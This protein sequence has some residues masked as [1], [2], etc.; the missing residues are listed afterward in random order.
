M[1]YVFDALH[2]G[3]IG[4]KDTRPDRLDERVLA[5]H[6]A[7]ILGK[8]VQ[9]VECLRPQLDL[10]RSPPQGASA[11]VQSVNIEPHDAWG[12]GRHM[13]NQRWPPE[14]T[15]ISA[16]YRAR[17]GYALASSGQHIKDPARRHDAGGLGR[18]HVEF[19]CGLELP[20]KNEGR[21]CL[22][23]RL[24]SAIS[25][26]RC[27]TWQPKPRPI[28]RVRRASQDCSGLCGQ[29]EARRAVQDL[30]A[31]DAGGL[32]GSLP[33]WLE[34]IMALAEADASTGWVTA[35][36]NLC[37]GLIY[38]SAEPRFRDEF[39]SDQLLVRRGAISR[40]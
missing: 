15:Q 34:M 16:D 12:D 19:R 40:V 33:Q 8:I 2:Q 26:P 17:R 22:P 30:V 35:H 27:P 39:F 6:P 23:A 36:A 38:A 28:A 21:A 14:F 24:P 25:G 32:A 29:I 7:P 1:P 10:L 5:D 20:H 18:S 13:L 9:D 31:A 37:A 3:T 4:D 11:Q